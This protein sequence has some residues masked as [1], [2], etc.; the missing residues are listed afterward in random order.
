M[1]KDK[2]SQADLDAADQ[3]GYRMPRQPGRYNLQQACDECCIDEWPPSLAQQSQKEDAD[4]NT[5]VKRFG[6][7]GQLP[8]NV[9]MPTYQDFDGVMDFQTAMNAIK[10]AEDSFMRMPANVRAR[11]QNDPA[12]FVEWCSDPTNLDEARKLGLAPPKPADPAPAP[13]PGEPGKPA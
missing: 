6:L 3:H 1:A 2:T 8:E 12:E 5:I 10:S 9:R 11:F 4:I 7:T 13:T